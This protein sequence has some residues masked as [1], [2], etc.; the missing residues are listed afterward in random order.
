[1]GFNKGDKVR[2]T[3]KYS[4]YEEGVGEI[5]HLFEDGA[6]YMLRLDG[7]GIVRSFFDYELEPF[8]AKREALIELAET[9]NKARVQAN[10]I[11]TTAPQWSIYGSIAQNLVEVLCLITGRFE[12]GDIYDA[13][14]DGV[15]VREALALVVK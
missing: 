7:S 6:S 9:L 11:E 10:A 13:L 12:V 1:M 14:I 5:T 8:D 4:K 15:T 2:I 3:P